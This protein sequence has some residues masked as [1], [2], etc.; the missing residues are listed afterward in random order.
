VLN[1]PLPS[2][3]GIADDHQRED[4]AANRPYPYEIGVGAAEQRVIY[5]VSENLDQ[6]CDAGENFV[7]YQPAMP[8]D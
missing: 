6:Q 5:P 4:G 2:S 1:V 8:A 7:E 3:N